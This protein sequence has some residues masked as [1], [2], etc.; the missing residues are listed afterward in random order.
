[1][2]ELK[3]RFNTENNGNELVWRVLIENTEYLAK[4]IEVNTKAYTTKDYLADGREKYHI[5]V[6]Y[7]HL[8]WENNN[9]IIT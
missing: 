8:S 7:T 6:P 2:K 4:N 9:L 1:M 5:T 3:I